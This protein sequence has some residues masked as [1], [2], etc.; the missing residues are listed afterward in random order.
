MKWFRLF[1]AF[2]LLVVFSPKLKHL[3]RPNTSPSLRSLFF[4]VSGPNLATRQRFLPP[5]C[6]TWR[7]SGSRRVHFS[8][9]DRV[10]DL[11]PLI[12]PSCSGK[13]D[14]ENKGSAGG[15]G[16][17]GR[18]ARLSRRRRRGSIPLSLSSA[19]SLVMLGEKEGG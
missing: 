18:V 4:S 5:P 15:G 10:S 17:D 14:A 19:R 1:H 16:T 7:S 9:G 6:Q 2:T 3:Q 11:P 12:F 8:G 13:R